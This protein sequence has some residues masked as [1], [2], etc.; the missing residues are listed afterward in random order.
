MKALLGA[1]LLVIASVAAA[2]SV[3]IYKYR[4]ADGK[5]RYSDKPLSGGELIEAFE[6][7]PPP[8]ASPQ[9]DTSKSDTAGEKRITKHLAELEAAWAEVQSSGRELAEAEAR[10]AAGAAPLDNENQG[11]APMTNPSSAVG[12]ATPAPPSAGGP[13]GN[14]RGGGRNAAYFERQAKLEAAV[15]AARRRNQDAW[16]RYNQLR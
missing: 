10:R 16:A 12:P 8:P 14:W 7:T 3:V 4:G 2:Q 6:Y 11:L 9:P 13:M 15:E 1:V 5:M